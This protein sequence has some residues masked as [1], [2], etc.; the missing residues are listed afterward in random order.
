MYYTLVVRTAPEQDKALGASSKSEIFRRKAEFYGNLS[1][2]LSDLETFKK[3][4]ALVQDYFASLKEQ[5][6][7]EFAGEYMKTKCEGIEEWH[8]DVLNELAQKWKNQ[9]KQDR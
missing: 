7:I 9:L 4:V 6:M 8:A 5:N 1:L 2:V 3:H